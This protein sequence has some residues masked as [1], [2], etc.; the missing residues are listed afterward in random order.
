MGSHE[1]VVEVR[2]T[3]GMSAAYS[4]IVLVTLDWECMTAKVGGMSLYGI[5]GT[6]PTDVFTVG[7]GGTI[8]HYNGVEWES[9]SSGVYHR[10]LDVWG[11]SPKEVF[12][13]GTWG[14]ILH[15]KP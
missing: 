2:D 9:M 11:F 6:S 15:S 3:E 14:Q 7:D 10:L 12:V 5:W 1:V 8:L 13:V 4:E